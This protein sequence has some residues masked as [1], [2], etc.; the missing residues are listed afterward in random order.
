MIR[1]VNLFICNY[2]IITYPMNRIEKNFLLVLIL[3]IAVVITSSLISLIVCLHNNNFY[4][5]L[6]ETNSSG[7]ERIINGYFT[8]NK[9][10]IATGL[11]FSKYQI[12]NYQHKQMHCEGTINMT[13]NYTIGNYIFDAMLKTTANLTITVETYQSYI[14]TKSDFNAI[15]STYYIYGNT[16]GD[17]LLSYCIYTDIDDVIDYIRNDIYTFDDITFWMTIVPIIVLFCLASMVALYFKIEHECL[18]N[19]Y[20]YQMI[21]E[22]IEHTINA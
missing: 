6:I 8:D 5:T 10:N 17:K 12:C 16:V 7:T 11:I 15:N 20:R 18:Q 22:P 4:Y 19:N 14:I 2:T 1:P 13:N 9:D 21:N 3:I